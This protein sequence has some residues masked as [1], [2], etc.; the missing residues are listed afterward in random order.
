MR[1]WEKVKMEIEKAA[2][3]LQIQLDQP[4]TNILIKRTSK[5]K[6]LK[7]FIGTRIQV[8]DT[9]VVQIE[10]YKPNEFVNH[11]FIKFDKGGNIIDR[12]SFGEII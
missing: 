8:G 11:Y 5:S 3:K 6:R 9:F 2:T 7:L 10:V 1:E 4:R 12:C